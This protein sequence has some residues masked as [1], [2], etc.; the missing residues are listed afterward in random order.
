MSLSTPIPSDD[1]VTCKPVGGK[2]ANV[3]LSLFEKLSRLFA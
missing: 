2:L 1:L 3:K